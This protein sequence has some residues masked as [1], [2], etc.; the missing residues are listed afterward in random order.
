MLDPGTYYVFLDGY[1][2][3]VTRNARGVTGHIIPW[4]YP[5]QMFGRTLAP[6]LACGNAMIFKPAELTPLTALWLADALYEAGLPPQM[7]SRFTLI[8]GNRSPQSTMFKEEIEDLKNRY[9]TRLTLHHVFSDER[10][11]F[12]RLTGGGALHDDN[13]YE[14][15]GILAKIHR[16]GLDDILPATGFV[17]GQVQVAAGTHL[18]LAQDGKALKLHA[19]GKDG[20][21]AQPFPA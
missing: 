10:H 8:Y 6:A 15:V 2:V 12:V 3:M 13:K 5:A 19:R 21:Q 14:V 16:R 20:R 7:L 17:H 18:D 11:F 9:L 4:N 1:T